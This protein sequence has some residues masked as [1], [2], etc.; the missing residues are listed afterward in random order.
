MPEVELLSE[1]GANYTHLR[2]LLAAGKWQEADEETRRVALK[3]V[4]RENQGLVNE[5]SIN[6]VPCTDLRTIDKL[7]VEYSQ[8]RFG[9]SVQKRIYDEVGRDW[10]KM[11]DR[12]GWRVE[13]NWLSISSLTYTADAP[14]GHLPGAGAWVTSLVWGLWSR[15]ADCFYNRVD[16]CQL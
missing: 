5:E 15:S 14:I 12:V 9:F 3:I 6:K 8:G 16:M 7:W 11:G 13:R 10:E 4:G 2:D 1:V